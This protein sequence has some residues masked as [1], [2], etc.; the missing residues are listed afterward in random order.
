MDK[1]T[2]YRLNP[3]FPECL[4]KTEPVKSVARDRETMIIDSIISDYGADYYKGHEPKISPPLETVKAHIVGFF[5]HT[6]PNGHIGTCILIGD[7]HMELYTLE[8]VQDFKR[9]FQSET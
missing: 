8:P 6:F 4:P 9:R 1:N 3:P 2:E 5:A 7:R